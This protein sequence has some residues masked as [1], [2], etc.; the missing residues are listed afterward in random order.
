MLK[1]F[2]NI[3]SGEYSGYTYIIISIILLITYISK[4]LMTNILITNN[5]ILIKLLLLDLSY[6]NKSNSSIFIKFK[7]LDAEIFLILHFYYELSHQPI[8]FSKDDIC[9]ARL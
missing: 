4:T 5:S 1:T 9:S 3:Q 8:S 2:Q 6:L 7:S